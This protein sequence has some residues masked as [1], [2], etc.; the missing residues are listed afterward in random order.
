MRSL[1]SWSS[2][3]V[4]I[5][6][7]VL[8]GCPKPVPPPP[9]PAP[10][11]A[12]L[13]R[14]LRL[15]SR[16]LD[17]L[18]LP[19]AAEAGYFV[20]TA[21]PAVDAVLARPLAAAPFADRLGDAL[22]AAAGPLPDPG[23]RYRKPELPGVGSPSAILDAL[24]VVAPGGDAVPAPLP[25]PPRVGVRLPPPQAVGAVRVREGP[26]PHRPPPASCAH[27]TPLCAARAWTRCST[28]G[29]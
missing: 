7:A 28:Q 15:A 29:S 14:G 26:D 23:T 11:E 8:I 20:P 13:E 10:G 18:E 6:V 2:A 3:A 1:R 4:A 21:Y 24:I 5:G 17:S 27:R 25:P 19:R 9:D 22:D 16:S 12:P